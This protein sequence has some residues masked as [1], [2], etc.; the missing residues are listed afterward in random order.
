MSKNNNKDKVKEKLLMILS[1]KSL[2]DLT[3]RLFHQASG[4]PLFVELAQ[5]NKVVEQD[6]S[7]AKEKAWDKFYSGKRVFHEGMYP[8]A[9]ETIGSH[10]DICYK[11]SLKERAIIFRK[12]TDLYVDSIDDKGQNDGGIYTEPREKKVADVATLKKGKFDS[13]IV[14]ISE[15]GGLDIEKPIRDAMLDRIAL[16]IIREGHKRLKESLGSFARDSRISERD[17]YRFIRYYNPQSWGELSKVEEAFH[18]YV[19]NMVTL[20]Q[21]ALSK[22]QEIDENRRWEIISN[23][24]PENK[25]SFRWADN[26]D[27]LKLFE[28][29]FDQ[30]Y[31]V[32][33]I[34]KA[35]LNSGGLMY[36]LKKKAKAILDI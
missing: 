34:D 17:A 16:Q 14:K 22:S 36:R 25:V 31:F 32:Q 35:L 6:I 2:E 9:Y 21:L 8:L 23:S 12:N 24:L 28:D 33:R 5:Y 1:D 27:Y 15:I 20:A 3:K 26:N 30:E 19:K 13:D 7:V 10:F 18:K 4:E 29:S 11:H